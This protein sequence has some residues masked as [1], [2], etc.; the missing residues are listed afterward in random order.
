MEKHSK[1]VGLPVYCTGNNK[2][3]GIIKDVLYCMEEKQA[4]AILL[5]EN[6]IMQK[7]RIILLKDISKI[8]EDAVIIR[9]E[10]AKQYMGYKKDGI[11]RD[12]VRK[13]EVNRDGVNRDGA[14]V[15]GARQDK[16]MEMK[17]YSRAG[18][19]LGIIKDVL[20]DC[21]TGNIEGVEISGGILQDMVEGRK[22]LPFIGRYEFGEDILL[23]DE[24]V[25]GEMT[26]TGGGIKNKLFGG[27]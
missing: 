2:K 13:N 11:K 7:K 24:D 6:G 9:S 17:V 5:Q 26:S 22:V 10:T 14:Q 15:N 25:V 16:I 27:K 12:R 8:G 19:E 18:E 1:V 23:V 4:K 3:L 21:E 20:F